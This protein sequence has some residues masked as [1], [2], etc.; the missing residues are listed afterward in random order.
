MF[1]LSICSR[2]TAAEMDGLWQALA[3]SNISTKSVEED[4]DRRTSLRAL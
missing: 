4:L 3:A 2:S 1:S